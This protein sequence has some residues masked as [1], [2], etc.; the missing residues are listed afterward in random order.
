MSYVCAGKISVSKY[1][2]KIYLNWDKAK[3]QY[4][5]F[6]TLANFIRPRPQYYETLID[7]LLVNCLK[8][9]HI[10]QIYSTNL[11]IHQSTIQ[12]PTPTRIESITNMSAYKYI[13]VMG[14]HCK[15]EK[16]HS[17]F[18]CYVMSCIFP[19]IIKFLTTSFTIE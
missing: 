4:T 8:G 19:S 11:P 16:L 10:Q 9:F 1:L 2:E 5:V 14:I 12:P 6:Q 15:R 3:K 17:I 7:N 18:L 13:Q